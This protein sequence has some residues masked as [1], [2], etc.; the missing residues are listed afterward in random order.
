MEAVETICPGAPAFSIAS[1]SCCSNSMLGIGGM[2]AR[3]VDEV[4]DHRACGRLGTRARA[5]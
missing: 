5:D 1:S 3:H 4:G 2:H